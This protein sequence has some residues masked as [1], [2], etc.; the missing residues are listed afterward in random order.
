MAIVLILLK[1]GLF[2]E[3]IYFLLY[4]QLTNT[5]Q[6]VVMEKLPYEHSELYLGI[7]SGGVLNS[8]RKVKS[9]VKWSLW[10]RL[11]TIKNIWKKLLAHVE[12]KNANICPFF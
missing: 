1:F 6:A 3:C 8:S 7:D 10:V 4:F 5:Q 9:I 11:C 12:E 2:S